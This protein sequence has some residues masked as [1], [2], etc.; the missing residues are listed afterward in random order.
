MIK[1]IMIKFDNIPLFS[2]LMKNIDITMAT[3]SD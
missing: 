1:L 2:F 3:C